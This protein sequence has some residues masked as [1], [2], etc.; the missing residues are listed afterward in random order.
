M[1]SWERFSPFVLPKSGEGCGKESTVV[2]RTPVDGSCVTHPVHQIEQHTSPQDIGKPLLRRNSTQIIKER[3]KENGHTRE[4]IRFSYTVIIPHVTSF[5]MSFSM[6]FRKKFRK[7]IQYIMLTDC[8][9]CANIY[10]DKIH[11]QRQKKNDNSYKK[12]RTLQ[13]T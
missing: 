12:G 4:S 2:A 3:R 6:Q 10:S 1:K 8:E 11:P 13:C 5:V 7:N 9:L